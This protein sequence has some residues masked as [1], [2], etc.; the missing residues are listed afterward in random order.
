MPLFRSQEE[1]ELRFLCHPI[2]GSGNRRD[3]QAYQDP[4][5]PRASVTA[6]V[7]PRFRVYPTRKRR[8]ISGAERSLG[9]CR[10]PRHGSKKD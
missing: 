8:Y 7:F 6:K 9:E 4:Q 5:D 2:D 10:G 1:R 3:G